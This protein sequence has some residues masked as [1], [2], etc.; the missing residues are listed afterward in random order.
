MQMDKAS[1]VGD[2]VSYVQDMKKQANKLKSE[3]ASL[4]SSLNN[5][6]EN[7]QDRSTN[8]NN[9][10][11]TYPTSLNLKIFKVRAN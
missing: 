9:G 2:A 6:G 11:K 7:Y 1:I 4:E 3:I 10:M 8:L 5:G